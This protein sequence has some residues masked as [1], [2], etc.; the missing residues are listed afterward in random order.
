MNTGFIIAMKTEKNKET[1]AKKKKTKPTVKKQSPK[2]P[3]RKAI[4][5]TTFRFLMIIQTTFQTSTSAICLLM[6]NIP[7]CKN[8]F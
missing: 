7:I 6:F 2:Q 1:I 5:T 4:K 3:Q 8:N